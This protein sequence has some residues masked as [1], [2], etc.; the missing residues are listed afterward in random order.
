VASTASQVITLAQTANATYYPAFV[1]ANNATATGKSV[2]TTSS[3]SITPSTGVVRIGSTASSTSTQTGALLV[4]GGA[5]I[6]GDVNIGGALNAISKSFVIPH[7]SIPGK[8]L[9]HGSLEG[10]EF[11][12]YVRGRLQGSV[13]ELPDYWI[14]LVD[15]SSITVQLTPIG[16]YQKLFVQ[17]IDNNR[18]T[19][20]NGNLLNTTIDCYYTVW[21]ERKDLGKLEVES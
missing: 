19:I 18:I 5:G 16:S 6:G 12:V 20:G 4:T 17:T 10:P 3:F 15:Q 7:P 2:Y 14:N 21:A 11:G 1:D 13:I 8:T 9:R